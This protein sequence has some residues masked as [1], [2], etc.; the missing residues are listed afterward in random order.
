MLWENFL[1]FDSNQNIFLPSLSFK[2]LVLQHK[3]FA[4]YYLEIKFFHYVKAVSSK[5]DCDDKNYLL[6]KSM[7]N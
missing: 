4:L 1:F 5:G 7:D 6:G 2:N 3:Y